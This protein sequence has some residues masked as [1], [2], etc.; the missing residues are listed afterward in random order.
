M[1]IKFWYF[2]YLIHAVCYGIPVRLLYDTE[3]QGVRYL[4]KEND[5]SSDEIRLQVPVVYYGATYDSIFVNS[6]GFLSF[7]TEIPHFINIE[8]PLDYPIIAP[9]YTNVDITRAGIIS[10]YE[11]H[12]PSLLQRATENIHESFLQSANFQARSIFVV[13]WKDVGYYNQGFDKLNTYQA[14]IATNGTETYVEFLYPENGIQWIQGTGDESGLPDARAQ[15]GFLSADGDMHLLPGSGTEQVKNLERWSN[16]GLAG[17]FIYR[18]DGKKIQEPDAF[19]EDYKTQE[20][21][22]KALTPCHSHANCIDYEE[23][24]CCECQDGY[25]GNGKNCVENN[26]PL[27]VSGK[28]NGKL[29]GEKLENLDLQSYVVTVDG[30][31]YTAISKIP[32][33]IGAD[34]QIL[35]ILGGVIGYLFAKPIRGAVNGFQITGGLLNHTSNIRFLNSSHEV[36][37]NQKFL[38]LD[39]FDQVKVEIDIQGDI[40]TLNAQQSVIIDE[41][42]EQY[43]HTADGVLQMSSERS[44]LLDGQIHVFRV[45]QTL[46]FDYCPF[47]KNNVGES[48]TL[49]VAKNFISYEEREQI[50]RFGLSNKITPIGEYDPCEEGRS[51][52]GPDSSCVVDGTSFDCVC[53]PGYQKLY[54]GDVQA[55]VDVNECQTGVHDCDYNSQCLNS[56]GNYECICNPSFE[57]SGRLCVPAR[58]CRNVTCAENSECFESDEIAVCK[59]IPGFTGDGYSCTPTRKETCDVYNNC[60]PLGVC[61]IDLGTNE[62]SCSCLAGYQG[63]GYTC[64]PSQPDY[65]STTTVAGTTE[66]EPHVVD[67]T[68]LPNCDYNAACSFKPELQG[69]TCTCN[70]GYE[71]DGYHCQQSRD[72]CLFLDNCDIHA[73][74]SYDKNVGKSRCICAQQY[75]GDGYNCTL[76]AACS[77]NQDCAHTEECAYHNGNY[78]CLCKEG[79]VRDSQYICVPN[80]DSCGGGICVENSECLYDDNVETFYCHCKSGYHGDGISECKVKPIGCDTLNNCG[81]HATCQYE[82]SAFTYVCKCNPGFFGDGFNCYVERNCNVDPTMCDKN[83]QCYSDAERN[84]FCQCNSGFVGSGEVCKEIVKNERNFLLVNQGMATL[85]IPLEPTKQNPG[86]PIQIKP[87]QTA[88]GLDIDCLEGRVYWSDISGRAIRSSLYNGS[89]KVDFINSGI[90]SPEGLA[91]DYVSRNIYWTDSMS[92]TIEVANLDS[93]RRRKLFSTALVNPRGIAVHPQR[94]K[95]FWSDWDRQHPKIE[96]ANADG[97]DRRIFIEVESK[98]LPNSLVIDFDTESLCYA[99]AGTKKIECV[100][101]DSRQRVTVAVNCSY[102]FGIAIVDNQVYWSDWISKKIERAEKYSSNRLPPLN[103]PVGGSGNKIFGLVAVPNHCRNLANVCQYSKCPDEHICLPDGK[104][105]KSCVCARSIDSKEEPQCSI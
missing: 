6:N 77:S 50:I 25:F 11:T 2:L 82:E 51:R 89:D 40:P 84:F 41:Y 73:T 18:V 33:S 22:A 105:S 21:C 10:F 20:T 55:C 36:Y 17:Q 27:R 93:R 97:S 71:G 92:D 100:Q 52:C 48:W 44:Y 37:I 104:G 66:S 24:F 16:I 80:I 61:S 60:S 4:L 34:I 75:S 102:P 90:G 35:Q 62:Y 103:I 99:D 19:P 63:D 12:D 74:C 91:V 9:F 98:S 59:C 31:A 3:V 26:K 56:I 29:N 5:V 42:S 23:G 86:K 85:K 47:Q 38:G 39:V 79:Y 95:I 7:Q 94:G 54:S 78:E 69:Y 67:C 30:R 96:W 28:V 81:Y 46:K 76:V 43:T 65:V 70:D 64:V 45:E 68:V 49:K 53:N 88:V 101:I 72:S 83:A 32:E 13:T 1:Y 14:V 15:V 57:K 8:F 58:S 87:Y